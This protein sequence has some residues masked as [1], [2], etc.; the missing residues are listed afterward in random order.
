MNI[1]SG[2]YNEKDIRVGIVASRFIEIIVSKLID[3]AG[4]GSRR[5]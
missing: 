2:L 5:F 1:I 3:G 4:M